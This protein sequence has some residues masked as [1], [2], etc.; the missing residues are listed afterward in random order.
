[1]R[2]SA[3]SFAVGEPSKKHP[4]AKLF[5]TN[6]GGATPAVTDF[7]DAG[8]VG[9]PQGVAFFDPRA[10][11]VQSNP[12]SATNS[13]L[14]F[15][16]NTWTRFNNPAAHELDVCIFTTQPP[17]PCDASGTTP[18]FY[19]IGISGATLDP[20]LPIDRMVSAVIDAR[21]GAGRIRFFA[22]APTDGSTVLLPVVASDLGLAPGAAAFSYTATV[23]NE[24]GDAAG[25]PGTGTFDAFSQAITVSDFPVV[26]PGGFAA[27]TVNVDFA[28]LALTPQLGL[29]VVVPDNPANQREGQVIPIEKE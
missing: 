8:L 17:G 5:V 2:S 29:M 18:D 24:S 1:V 12:I 7:Y 13:I 3:F 10:L 27:L 19:V 15:A 25:L 28:Q 23:F 26:A 20:S 9:P 4:T 21:T 22:D 11:G 14:V 16:L 6:F